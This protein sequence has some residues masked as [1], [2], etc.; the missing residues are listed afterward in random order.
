MNPNLLTEKAQEAIAAAQRQAEE[1]QHATLDVDHLVYHS[2][3]QEGG[4]VRRTIELLGHDPTTLSAELEA[5][6]IDAAEA[7][8]TRL[9][10]RFREHSVM[11]CSRPK[12][13]SPH[14]E[15]TT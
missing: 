11:C 1:R 14:S 6:L 13:K 2:L 4:I 5:H 10:R 9:N 12:M 15:T 3:S 7:S 8:S